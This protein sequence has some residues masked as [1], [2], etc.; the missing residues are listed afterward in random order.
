MSSIFS[1]SVRP[2][3]TPA[4]ESEKDDG[5]NLKELHE[6]IDQVE[7]ATL[8]STR[9]AIRMLYEANGAGIKTLNELDRQEEKLK[10]V[11]RHL[12]D[13]DQKLT[14][15]Q[16]NVNKL[17]SMFGGIRNKLSFRSSKKKEEKSKKVKLSKKASANTAEDEAKAIGD[18]VA[19]TLIPAQ[20]KVITGSEREKEINSNLDSMSKI[21]TNLASMGREI[22]DNLTRN[23][24]L[25][26]RLGHKIEASDTRIKNQN[27]EIRSIFQS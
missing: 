2:K 17:K 7:D 20:F 25:L 9:R 6:R 10:A 4:C 27:Q 24:P 18:K 14:E 11:D 1:Y 3:N 16:K 21:L 26:D 13:I 5:M 22:N 23:D 12:D 19:D 8:E 15:T